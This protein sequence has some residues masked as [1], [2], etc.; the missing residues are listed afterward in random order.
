M[1][2]IQIQAPKGAEEYF[3]TMI[4]LFGISEKVGLIFIRHIL[5]GRNLT[6]NIK[7]M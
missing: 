4:V 6:L 3:M 2:K 5:D 1:S 7:R